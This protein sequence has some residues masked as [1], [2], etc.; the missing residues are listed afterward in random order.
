MNKNMNNT[1]SSCNLSFAPANYFGTRSPS[2]PK[3]PV[4]PLVGDCINDWTGEINKVLTAGMG[5][6]NGPHAAQ[7][8]R[9]T[10]GNQI[11]SDGHGTWYSRAAILAKPVPLKIGDN[12]YYWLEEEQYFC[13]K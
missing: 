4:G 13:R 7:N 6:I 2:T 11:F 10:G 12:S 9:F 8:E 3:D 5:V 1:S